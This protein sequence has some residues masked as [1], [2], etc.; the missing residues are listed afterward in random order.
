MFYIKQ[1]S[2]PII[3]R[4]SFCLLR[5]ANKSSSIITLM[6]NGSEHLP[7]NWPSRQQ[8]SERKRYGLH[9]HEEKEESLIRRMTWLGSHQRPRQKDHPLT[10]H[11]PILPLSRAL[12]FLPRFGRLI[13]HSVQ[14]QGANTI[15]ELN[16]TLSHTW[17]TV[18]RDSHASPA[19][20][21]VYPHCTG[22]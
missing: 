8:V 5:H 14:S 1:P 10:C 9:V 3:N 6:W 19:T 13:P 16:E 20:F 2:R 7:A 15:S 22:C 17:S 4:I 12:F 21:P 11:S 18:Q